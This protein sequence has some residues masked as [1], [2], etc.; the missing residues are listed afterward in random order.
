M[1]IE[2]I[3]WAKK[4]RCGCP[5]AKA[6]LLELANWARPDGV[7]QFRRVR[8]IAYVVELSERTIQRVLH[9]LED[10]S[11]ADAV[12]QKKAGLNLIRRVESYRADG[13]QQANSFV[14]VGYFRQGD[15]QSPPADKVSLGLCPSDRGGGDTVVTPEIEIESKKNDSPNAP[16]PARRVRQQIASDWAAPPIEK[17]PSIARALASQW[18]IGAYEAEADA[19][20]QHSLGTGQRNADWNALWVSKV[21]TQHGAMMRAA[22]AGVRYP[23]REATIAPRIK[24]PPLPVNARSQEDARSTRLRE[25]LRTRVDQQLWYSL[26]EP[27]AFVFDVPGLKVVVSNSVAQE[28]LETRY[29]S[30]MRAAAQSIEPETTWVRIEAEPLGMRKLSQ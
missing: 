10:D 24:K 6:V 13:G 14:L 29:P 28:E 17:L 5:F 12:T 22:K 3:A 4:Q 21:Q 25:L 7:C 2:T 1:S 16:K 11:P 20:F 27:A 9:R 19:F 30:M 23:S 8:D 15:R 18:P 26:F